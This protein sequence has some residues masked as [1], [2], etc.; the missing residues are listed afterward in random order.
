MDEGISYDDMLTAVNID[1]TLI[2]PTQT[3]VVVLALIGAFFAASLR[4]W[5]PFWIRVLQGK[6]K[7]K[8]DFNPAFIEIAIVSVVVGTLAAITQLP[9]KAGP[10]VVC[11]IAFSVT[12]FSN[13]ALNRKPP[14]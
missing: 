12:Y 9:E 8:E 3:E 4:T 2:P 5:F 13:A 1:P 10:I 6:K 11:L 14:G 7:W